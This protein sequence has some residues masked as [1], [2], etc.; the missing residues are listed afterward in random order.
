MSNTAEELTELIFIMDRSG[1]MA[2]IKDDMEGG[3]WTIITEN[4][5]MPGKCVVSL[6]TF[7]DRWEV[8]FEARASGD[9]RREHCALV[10]RAG[11]ALFDGVVKSLAAA[12]DRILKMDETKRPAK[13]IVIVVTDGQENSSK[14]NSAKDANDI[15]TR[16]NEKYK[17]QAIFLAN[18]EGGFKDNERMRGGMMRGASGLANAQYDSRT[19]GGVQ[20]MAQ[21]VANATR[22]Y[23]GGGQGAVLQ[24]DPNADKDNK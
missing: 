13:V 12:E 22:N 1:S 16:V 24:Y 4:H 17:W 10:P 18:G 3:I 20:V 5:G 2:S 14:E 15:V 7:D 21:C 19:P 6:Y 9:V 23:R 11:T 8:A